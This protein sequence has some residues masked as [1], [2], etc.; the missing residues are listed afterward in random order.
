[1]IMKTMNTKSMILTVC[2]LMICMQVSA[3]AKYNMLE[4]QSTSTMQGTGSIHKPKITAIDAPKAEYTYLQMQSTSIMMETG[5]IPTPFSD[6]EEDEN[7]RQGP[8]RSFDQGGESGRA[9]E[10]PVGEPWVMLVFAAAAAATVAI[11]RRLVES[12]KQAMN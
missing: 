8:R 7:Y 9:D 10:Y 5:E 4:M 6:I 11:R 12:R 1:M 2:A 3:A